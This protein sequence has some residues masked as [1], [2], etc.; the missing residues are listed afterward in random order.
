MKVNSNFYQIL[1]SML[2]SSLYSQ[3]GDIQ[4]NRI[5]DNNDN[6]QR[7]HAIIH[8]INDTNGII[9]NN[10]M[11]NAQNAVDCDGV[12]GLV[13]QILRDADPVEALRDAIAAGHETEIINFTNR[14]LIDTG[15]I[16]REGHIIYYPDNRMMQ[17]FLNRGRGNNGD[18]DFDNSQRQNIAVLPLNNWQYNNFNEFRDPNNH[19]E[20]NHP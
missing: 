12:V 2:I 4:D 20:N 7:P 3:G 6:Q 1:L 17:E 19:P 16:N 11:N 8:G 9:V 15:Q 18:H 10:G 14:R 5:N 13:H